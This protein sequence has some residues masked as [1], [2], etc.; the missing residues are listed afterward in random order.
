MRKTVLLLLVL[1]L[2]LVAGCT[3]QRQKTTSNL[4]TEKSEDEQQMEIIENVEVQREPAHSPGVKNITVSIMG[5]EKVNKTETYVTESGNLLE[6]L[7]ENNLGSE[8]ED[9]RGYI[10]T[11]DGYT[12]NLDNGEWWLI[13]K[14]SEAVST[15]ADQTVLEDGDTLY[16][17]LQDLS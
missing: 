16:F 15:S 4:Q 13:T 5:K 14:N 7:V 17:E 8:S 6:F 11:I 12:A 9:I 10:T 1:S 2:F 3:Q